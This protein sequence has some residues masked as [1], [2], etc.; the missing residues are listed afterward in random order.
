MKRYVFDN[1]SAANRP[2][3]NTMHFS[4]QRA[5]YDKVEAVIRKSVEHR[6]EERQS[7]KPAT[8]DLIGA[9]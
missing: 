9:N 3:I 4:F 6:A 2:G 1:R 8:L 7:R 5:G